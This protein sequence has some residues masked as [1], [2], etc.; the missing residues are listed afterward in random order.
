MHK[1]NAVGSVIIDAS[2][3]QFFRSNI[4]G[5]LG[6]A[7]FDPIDPDRYF[8]YDYNGSSLK[9]YYLSTQ[10][11]E[12][13]KDFGT[14][15][16]DL[17][18]TEDVIDATGKYLIVNLGGQ[19]K[20]VEFNR[21]T[22]AISVYTGSFPAVTDGGYVTISP[23]GSGVLAIS[24]GVKTWY[25]IDHVNKKLDSAGF[26]F[27]N[28]GGDHGTV[29]SSND[30]QTYFIK[31]SGDDGDIHAYNVRTGVEKKYTAGSQVN[32]PLVSLAK[33]VGW[34]DDTHFSNIPKGTYRDWVIISTEVYSDTG[35]CAAADALNNANPQS[36]WWKYRQEILMVNVLSGEI[37]NLAHH[38]SRELF[39]YCSTP[40]VN[41]N[42]D[43]TAAVFASNFGA[44]S[45]GCGYSDIYKIELF[46]P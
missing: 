29:V 16:G 7:T 34:C 40:R 1:T 39:R 37:R 20:V 18:G 28:Q 11:S 3:G 10:T 17:G 27:L 41:A 44:T 5:M 42:W 35:N 36:N 32:R 38:R 15:L 4:P 13:L 6:D 14:V 43:G 26:V 21:A 2:S 46:K 25:S 9:A 33:S 45:S 23:D 22:K 30:G 31:P 12:T 24:G 8:Y 19:V